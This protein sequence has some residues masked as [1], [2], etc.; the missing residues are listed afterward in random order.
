MWDKDVFITG[1]DFY[2]LVPSFR[3]LE[4]DSGRKRGWVTGCYPS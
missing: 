3:K 2:T 4:E 1:V